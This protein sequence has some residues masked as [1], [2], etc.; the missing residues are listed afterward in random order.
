[1]NISRIIREEINRF[2]IS[3]ELSSVLSPIAK[4]LV[5]Y[6]K[7]IAAFPIQDQNL[8]ERINNFTKYV[9]QIY[10]AVNR[11]IRNNNILSEA[12]LSDY[13]I[14]LPRELGGN[15]PYHFRR[16][17]YATERFFNGNRAQPQANGVSG[18]YSEGRLRS[19]PLS[20]LLQQLENWRGVMNNV[21]ARYNT[22]ENR[23]LFETINQTFTVLDNLN[24]NYQTL[25]QQQQQQQQQQQTT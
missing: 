23:Q 5:E 16:G 8:K 6:G 4:R 2:L 1:M 24:S 19:V 17:Y 18:E 11:C 12:A 20:Q 3:E 15:I 22:P 14:N 25:S 21:A 13:G 10:Y 7:K 9:F